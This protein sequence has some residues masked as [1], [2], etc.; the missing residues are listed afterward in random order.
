MKRLRRRG[1]RA[2][3]A[4]AYK[5]REHDITATER[6]HGRPFEMGQHPASQGAAG[7]RP[8]EAV[9]EAVE[10][11]HRRRQDGRPR[12]GQ[13]PAAAPGGQGGQGQLD[14]QGQH[15][16][17][18]QEG[19]GRRRRELRGDPLRGLRPER[20]R[21]HRRGD[22][23]QPQPHRLEHPLDLRQARRQPRRDRLGRLPVRP[24]GADR[25]PGLG[26]DRRGRARGGDRGRGRGRRERRGRARRLVR[27]RRP[28]RGVGGARGGARRGRVD[29]A[30]LA[31]ADHDRAR[32][33]GGAGA[34]AAD[35]GARGR[36]RR[37]VGDRERRDPGRRSWR[38][39]DGGRPSGGARRSRDGAAIGRMAHLAR[40][41][42][43]AKLSGLV[44][45]GEAADALRF[46]SSAGSGARRLGVGGGGRFGRP[47]QRAIAS[48]SRCRRG[49]CSRRCSRT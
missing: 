5:A 45:R 21:D 7:R 1:L 40:R 15:R 36:R 3:R 38:S 12:S 17:G 16:P 39:S 25:L 35:R 31:A 24:Q 9:L 20:G 43:A 27:R 46:D 33:R 41:I 28:R 23:R 6:P 47:A 26:R 18:D 13:E 8:L 32:P 29:A 34:D 48:A 2:A 37:A 44:R 14:A 10:G 22:D 30:G 42:F 19:A 4:P 49:R 11:D